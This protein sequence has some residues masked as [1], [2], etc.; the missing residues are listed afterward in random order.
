M[1]NPFGSGQFA[2]SSPCPAI[3]DAW[4]FEAG[5]GISPQSHPRLLK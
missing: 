1:E 4:P 5:S 3:N 2:R